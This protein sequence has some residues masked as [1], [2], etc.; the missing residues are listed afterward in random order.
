MQAAQVATA[1][2]IQLLTQL[3]TAQNAPALPRPCLPKVAEPIAFDG[4]MDD[5]ESFITS[6]TLYINARASEFG[7]QETK[8]LW[9]MS[10]CNKG[11]ARDWRKIEVQKVNDGTS[12]LELVE[13][14]YDEICQRFGD[15][16]RMATKILKLRTMKQGNKTAMEHV[17]DFQK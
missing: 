12:E 5:V 4:K 13:Q 10:Y 8:I 15:T 16:D 17:Q 14:L 7:D 6:C 2:Q 11:M 3:I 9:V 1:A